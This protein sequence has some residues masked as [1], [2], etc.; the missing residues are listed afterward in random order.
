MCFSLQLCYVVCQH[1]RLNRL[2]ESSTTESEQ[3]LEGPT[4]VG[5]GV[6]VE[7]DLDV[8]AINDYYKQIVPFEQAMLQG[9][10][11]ASDEDAADENGMLLATFDKKKF[12]IRKEDANSDDGEAKVVEEVIRAINSGKAR[13]FL[14]RTMHTINDTGT[15]LKYLLADTENEDEIED[16]NTTHEQTDAS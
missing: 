4:G 6:K 14:F 3:I 5:E 9:S 1:L 2:L 13:V 8:A 15:L 7:A 12:K 11:E 16:E 10:W